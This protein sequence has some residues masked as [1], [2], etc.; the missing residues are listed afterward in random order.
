[1]I[2]WLWYSYVPPCEYAN[3]TH[4]L[5]VAYIKPAVASQGT[6]VLYDSG[7][8]FI[9][10]S[11]LVSGK[12]VPVELLHSSNSRFH[13]DTVIRG[14]QLQRARTIY[15]PQWLPHEERL[16]SHHNHQLLTLTLKSHSRRPL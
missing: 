1:M 7:R 13:R 6:S 14:I 11:Y 3:K 16:I 4:T 8:S 2:K 15:P 5:A 12:L 10:D 9:K